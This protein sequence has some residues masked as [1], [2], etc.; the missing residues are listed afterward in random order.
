MIDCVYYN[1]A[2]R[3]YRDG[4]VERLFKRKGWKCVENT[5]NDGKG[6]NHIKINKLIILRHRLIAFCFLGLKNISEQKRGDDVIDH[7]NGNPLTN[8][9][10]NLRI[11]NGSGNQHNRKTAKGY[12]FNKERG[13]Y[14]AQIR[15]N[16]KLIYLGQYAIEDDARTAYLEGKRIHH[17]S[18]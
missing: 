1:N 5:A 6:Y 18:I 12:Y 10:D 7:K 15:L 9:V 14:Q 2:I 17:P 16:N 3:C 4:R 13:K 8:C 11:T